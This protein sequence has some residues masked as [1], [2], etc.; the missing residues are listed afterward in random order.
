MHYERINALY[1]GKR[2]ITSGLAKWRSVWKLKTFCSPCPFVIA[3]VTAPQSAT[4]PSRRALY[5]IKSGMIEIIAPHPCG[6]RTVEKLDNR[7]KC[8][9]TA[10]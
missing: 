10:T 2:Q 9:Y 1:P 5:D 3:Q 8:L 6:A 4:L 7:T